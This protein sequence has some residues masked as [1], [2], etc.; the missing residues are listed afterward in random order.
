MKPTMILLLLIGLTLCGCG[1][2]AVP[3]EASTVPVTETTPVPETTPAAETQPITEVPSSTQP[4]NL[5]ETVFLPFARGEIGPELD[6][7]TARLDELGYE[8][9]MGEGML[10]VSDPEHP[11]SFLSGL[12][13]GESIGQLSYHYLIHQ[14]EHIDQ[15]VQ[16][17]AMVDFLYGIPQYYIGVDWMGSGTQVDTPEEIAAYMMVDGL[18]PEETPDGVSRA[19]MTDVLGEGGEFLSNDLVHPVYHSVDLTL[20]GYAQAYSEEIGQSIAFTKAAAVDMDGDGI[21]EILLWITRNGIADDGVLVLH[22]ADNQIYGQKFA[23][24][25][26]FDIKTDGT[27]WTSGGSDNDGPARLVFEDH[28]WYAQPLSDESFEEKENVQWHPFPADLDELMK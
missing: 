25:Q 26:L 19:K 28:S 22:F 8:W 4:W 12:S 27:F 10:S 18:R 21:Q 3:T 7:V 23:Y 11:G 20:S 6:D 9:S 13:G 24:R 5:F 14:G 16:R 15:T 1:Q 2:A 17:V